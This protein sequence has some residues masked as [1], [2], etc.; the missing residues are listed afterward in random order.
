M[1]VGNRNDFQIFFFS[2]QISKR[3][4]CEHFF[5][6]S[7]GSMTLTCFITIIVI[8]LSS[9]NNLYRATITNYSTVTSQLLSVFLKQN[10]GSVELMLLIERYQEFF[11]LNLQL[12][13]SYI[14]FSHY[15]TKSQRLF[16][17]FF[18]EYCNS[19]LHSLN[20]RLK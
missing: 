8:N 18:L 2:Y 7:M 14:K 9:F 19:T 15:W 17:C 16:E 13:I 10:Y 5:F 11:K 20:I 12:G 6:S 1:H 4:T 3:S